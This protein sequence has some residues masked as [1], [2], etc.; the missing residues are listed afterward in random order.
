M[1]VTSHH[2]AIIAGERAANA[3][4]EAIDSQALPPTTT[5][6]V[7]VISLHSPTTATQHRKF[8]SVSMVFIYRFGF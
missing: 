6:F 7:P 5:V 4:N 1:V 2:E 8:K 3:A